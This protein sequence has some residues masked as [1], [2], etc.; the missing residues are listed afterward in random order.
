MISFNQKAIASFWLNVADKY[1]LLSQTATKILL[2]FATRA[3]LALT[4]MKSGPG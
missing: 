3:F 1:P 4:N 2:P